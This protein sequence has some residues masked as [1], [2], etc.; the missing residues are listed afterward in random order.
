MVYSFARVSAGVT[1][2]VNVQ[3]VP[4][5]RLTGLLRAPARKNALGF[6]LERWRRGF[7]KR[8]VSM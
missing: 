5:P 6:N 8:L 3:G 7:T 2:R 1:L 4:M